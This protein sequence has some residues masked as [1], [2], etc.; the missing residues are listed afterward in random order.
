MYGPPR[1]RLLLADY[2]GEAAGC[3]APRPLDNDICEMKRLYVRPGFRFL[4]LGRKLCLAV[5]DAARDLGYVRMRLDTLASMTGA[6]A[7]YRALGFQPTQPYT[8]SPF[9]DAI[10]LELALK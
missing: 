1:G 3:V 9:E 2:N 7:L 8:H 4:G 5:I 10:F 6:L